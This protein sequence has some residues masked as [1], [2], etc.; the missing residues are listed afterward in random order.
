MRKF[1]II[2]PTLFLTAF[3]ST[4]QT[5]YFV[6]DIKP[7][8]GSSNSGNLVGFNGAVIFSANDGA[9]GDELWKSDGTAAGTVMI[10]DIFPGSVSGS[11]AGMVYV[12]GTVYFMAN[13]GTHGEELWKTDGTEAGTVLVKDI[14]PGAAHGMISELKANNSTLYFTA[15]DGIHGEELWK[16]NG[17]EAGTVLVK[18]I[19][20]GSGNGNPQ[21][22]V[23]MN[24]VLFFSATDGIHSGYDL[25]KSTG[26]EA[27][28]IMVKDIYPVVNNV[29][30]ESLVPANGTLFFAAGN[31][32]SALWKSDG[33]EA[34]TVQ[35]KNL[36]YPKELCVLND[37]LYFQ[38]KNSTEGAE[39]WKSDGT[40][41][42]TVMLKDTRMG[43]ASGNPNSFINIQ[44]TLFFKTDEGN[45]YKLWISDGTVAGTRRVKDISPEYMTN[46]NGMVYFSAWKGT[47][48]FADR[49]L[50]KSDGTAAGTVMVQS[51]A[52]TG[53]SN[54]SDILLTSSKVFIVA[55]DNTHGRE[56]WMA[57]LNTSV[58]GLPLTMVDFKGVLTGH[59]V[60]LK[61]KTLAEHNTSHFDIER[62]LN[63]NNFEKAVSVTAAGNSTITRQYQYTDA[64]VTLSGAPSVRYRLKMTD[65]DGKFTF[66]RIIAIYIGHAQSL[67]ML[68]PNPVS[69]N[70]MLVIAARKK[71]NLTCSIIDQGGRTIQQ[72]SIVINEGSNKVPVETEILTAGIYTISI[73]GGEIN[74]KLR[75][76][77][78]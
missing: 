14:N 26:T 56:L 11:P 38:G 22:L 77:K 1:Y 68:Y 40:N 6:K 66:S 55:T 25:W 10:K 74:E 17:T 35:V 58:G 62:S 36:I 70:T 42:G 15:H 72:R 31:P 7:G 18:D 46:I 78:Q 61:W 9:H 37:T 51:I 16:T 64:G 24:D 5:F 39:L 28:T 27:G 59:D 54:P 2:I 3:V 75:F 20:P 76:V 69:E 21:N 44:N 71:G 48:P 47:G 57:N 65:L 73:N 43:T 63:G 33:T 53:G 19:N 23:V 32:V 50:W 45:G 34:G 49:E 52:N 67:I 12:N 30:V 60:V 13:D 4:A 41:A 29:V 8:I